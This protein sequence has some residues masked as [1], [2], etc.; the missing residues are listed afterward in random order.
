M[1]YAILIGVIVIF[2]LIIAIV[3]FTTTPFTTDAP[4][5]EN[6]NQPVSIAIDDPS[7]DNPLNPEYI[8]TINKV[9]TFPLEPLILASNHASIILVINSELQYLLIIRKSNLP[10]DTIDQTIKE[11]LLRCLHSEK[12]D[13]SEDENLWKRILELSQYSVPLHNGYPI[14]LEDICVFDECIYTAGK[15]PISEDQIILTNRVDPTI[16]APQIRWKIPKFIHQTFESLV[17]PKPLAQ[18]AQQWRNLNP[19]YTWM[20]WT[21][22]DRRNFIRDNFDSNVLDAYDSLYPGAFKAD[23]WRCCAVYIYG[24]VY[25]DIKLFP[26]VSLNQ[27]IS[28]QDD[29]ILTLD[30]RTYGIMERWWYNAFFAFPPKHQLIKAILDRIVQNVHQRMLPR[31]PVRILDIT[32]PGVWKDVIRISTHRDHTEGIF[33][34]SDWGHVKIFGHSFNFGQPHSVVNG[35]NDHIILAQPPHHLPA[36]NYWKATGKKRYDQAKIYVD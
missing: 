17:V 10:K 8:A 25:A 7:S 29:L 18:C 23:L 12:I 13:V 15:Y 6:A 3:Y 2:I 19:D 24:G 4:E 26:L 1:S 5:V 20:Y 34:Y 30:F 28:P 27:M 36:I 22:K 33:N 31:G 9:P 11:N 21:S 14:Y 32:G 16:P 35:R